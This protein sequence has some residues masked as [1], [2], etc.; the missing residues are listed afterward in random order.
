[1]PNAPRVTALARSVLADVALLDGLYFR[2]LADGSM[3]LDAFRHS[4]AQFF[5]AVQFYARPIAALVARVPDPK[6]RLD[7]VHNLV[8]EHGD[9]HEAKFHQTTFG[10]FL[11]T[12][13]TARP[14]DGPAA[15][16]HAFNTT[17]MG[18]CTA[19]PVAVGISCL[20][21]IELAFAGVSGLIGKSVVARGW[22][23][24]ERLVHYT[25][26]A[27]LDVEHAEEFFEMVEAEAGSP[28]VRSGLALGAY[29]F[30]RLYRDLWAEASRAGPG[31]RPSV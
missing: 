6:H 22:V 9:L 4:Q 27:E 7:L 3:S 20:G 15:P 1:M 29:V 2:A 26:H 31:F 17:L 11:G 8:E 18:A 28:D 25:V 24:A 10:D 30:D 23:P 13:G 5:Y 16:V 12:I 19:E 21:V 14:T